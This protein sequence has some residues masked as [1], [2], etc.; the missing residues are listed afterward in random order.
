M[1]MISPSNEHSHWI[2]LFSPATWDQ[3]VAAGAKVSGRLSGGNAIARRVGHV[4]PHSE[5][6][7]P[8]L[9]ARRAAMDLRGVGLDRAGCSQAKAQKTRMVRSA[10][11]DEADA[12]HATSRVEKPCE[13]AAHTAQQLHDDSADSPVRLSQER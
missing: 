5:G 10:G 13:V 9:G 3:F 7:S 6:F 8:R 4:L 2:Q 1:A 12:Q 11:N